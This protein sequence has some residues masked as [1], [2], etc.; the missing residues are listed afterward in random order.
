MSTEWRSVSHSERHSFGAVHLVCI[1]NSKVVFVLYVLLL[2]MSMVT[3]GRVCNCFRSHSVIIVIGTN[4][5]VRVVD[6]S[7][8]DRMQGCMQNARVRLWRVLLWTP[9]IIRCRVNRVRGQCFGSATFRT[10]HG[11]VHTMGTQDYPRSHATNRKRRQENSSPSLT[12]QAERCNHH[13]L[14]NRRPS[15]LTDKYRAITFHKSRRLGCIPRVCR[16][17]AVLALSNFQRSSG[18]SLSTYVVVS[19]GSKIEEKCHRPHVFRDADVDWFECEWK[20][21][22]YVESWQ[23]RWLRFAC[24]SLGTILFDRGCMPQAVLLF[25]TRFSSLAGNF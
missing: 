21:A 24:V 6:L 23:I 11:L 8:G 2:F 18:S 14:S 5:A 9:R 13:S 17:S 10:R 1:E 3:S 16:S 22:G 12:R 7:R 15:V 25:R 20:Q 19:L 4:D